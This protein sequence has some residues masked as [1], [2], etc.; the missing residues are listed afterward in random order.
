MKSKKRLLLQN[1]QSGL[2]VYLSK[3]NA[4]EILIWGKNVETFDGQT[5]FKKI[6]ILQNGL[7]VQLFN[8]KEMCF[9][10]KKLN[11]FFLGS[12]ST[13]SKIFPFGE[14]AASIQ[15]ELLCNYPV[16]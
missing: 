16:N 12:I 1:R 15:G 4:Y 7:R 8:G 9:L 11:W 10:F 6:Y 14:I 2:K 13:F 3:R 5:E